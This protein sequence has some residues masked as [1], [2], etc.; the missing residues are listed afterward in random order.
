MKAILRK[1]RNNQFRF[2]LVGNNGEKIATSETYTSKAMAK[3]TLKKYFPKFKLDDQ[4]IIKGK[5]VI[6][7][8]LVKGKWVPIMST[9]KSKLN[10]YEGWMK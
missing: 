8:K 2:N 4:T 5:N 10:K 9:R 3:K 7:E 6:I 1:T